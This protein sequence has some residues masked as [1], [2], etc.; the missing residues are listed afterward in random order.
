ME[1]NKILV[2]EMDYKEI[3]INYNDD[4]RFFFGNFIE[5]ILAVKKLSFFFVVKFPFK[6]SKKILFLYNSQQ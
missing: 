1:I 3:I 6:Y 2:M 4:K 5:V